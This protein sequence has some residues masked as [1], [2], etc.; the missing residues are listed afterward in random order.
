MNVL[1]WFGSLDPSFVFLLT[2]PI[3]VAGAGLARLYFDEYRARVG[4]Q[5]DLN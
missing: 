2:L 1:D 4:A 5:R 3:A